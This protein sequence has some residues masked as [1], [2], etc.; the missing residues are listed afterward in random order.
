MPTLSMVLL[1]LLLF[2]VKQFLRLLGLPV[3]GPP[4]KRPPKVVVSYNP[5]SVLSRPKR[6]GPV[7]CFGMGM[8]G[9][10]PLPVGRLAGTA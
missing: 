10:A 8:M 7:V 6:T 1:H 2:T 3:R 4:S 5:G 9:K